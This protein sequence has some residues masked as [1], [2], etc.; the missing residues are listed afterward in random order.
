MC[1]NWISAIVFWEASCPLRLVTPLEKQGEPS[2]SSSR[3]CCGTAATKSPMFSLGNSSRCRT[4]EIGRALTQEQEWRQRRKKNRLPAVPPWKMIPRFKTRVYVLFVFPTISVSV[5]GCHCERETL[6]FHWQGK[7]KG[8]SFCKVILLFSGSQK[9][10]A[11]RSF[12]L[13]TVTDSFFFHFISLV[14]SDKSNK[15]SYKHFRY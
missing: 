13:Y 15:S 11:K 9:M 2:E 10:M 4:K 8:M 12:F 7:N 6:V 1:R 3:N 5:D 14:W